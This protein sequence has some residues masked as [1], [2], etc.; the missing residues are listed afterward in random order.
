MTDY[1]LSKY[2]AEINEFESLTKEYNE[3]ISVSEC[4]FNILGI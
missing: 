4:R 3:L 2:L 1:L